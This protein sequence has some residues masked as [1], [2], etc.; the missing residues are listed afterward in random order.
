MSKIAL[1][2]SVLIISLP[3]VGAAQKRISHS[4]QSQPFHTEN[5]HRQVMGYSENSYGC[6][7]QGITARREIQYPT[8]EDVHVGG[9]FRSSGTYVESYHRTAPDY[10]RLNNYSTRGNIN[11]YTGKRGTRSPFK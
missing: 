1:I 7:K 10:T 5:K 11:P 6:A 8:R 9:Y 3:G 4:W 2:L